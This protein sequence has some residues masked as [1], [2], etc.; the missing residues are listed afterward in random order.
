MNKINKNDIDQEE[1]LL[2][3]FPER[4]VK[5]TFIEHVLPSV[6]SFLWISSA[7][8]TAVAAWYLPKYFDFKLK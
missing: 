2:P 3:E 4:P 6:P 7:V 5:M 1:P 8:V